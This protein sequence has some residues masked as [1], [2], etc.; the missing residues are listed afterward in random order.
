MSVR[1]VSHALAGGRRLD[2]LL[3]GAASGPALVVHHGT[4]NDASIFAG[5][6]TFARAHNLRLVAISR[7]GYASSTRAR[8]RR[9]AAIADDVAQL[10]VALDIPWYIAAGHSGG[11]PHALACAALDAAHCR[12]VATLAGTGPFGVDGFDFMAGMDDAEFAAARAGDGAMR[13]WIEQHAA[14]LRDVSGGDLAAMVDGIATDADRL[15]LADPAFANSVAGSM[16]RAL[17]GGFDGW[18]DDGVAS[19][20]PWG[21]ELHD[22]A[23]PATIW[24]GDGDRLVPPAHGDWLAGHI[25][26]AVHNRLRGDGHFSIL[27]NYADAIIADLLARAAPAHDR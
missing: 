23:I 24:H 27:A 2:V 21:F 10:I 4:P 8:G 25:P 11:G 18:A 14:A 5:W 13:A 7:P 9:V 26:N 6:D 12:A 16:R 19:V 20:A 3:G 22:I 1:Y 15:A 17:A